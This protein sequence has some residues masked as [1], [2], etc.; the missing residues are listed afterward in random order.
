MWLLAD[1]SAGA[2]WWPL[3]R[4]LLLATVAV[5]CLPAWW[6]LLVGVV[7]VPVFLLAMLV[8]QWESGQGLLLLAAGSWGLL[9]LARLAVQV[10][11]PQR[12]QRVPWWGLA[13]GVLAQVP[14]LGGWPRDLGQAWF[15]FGALL[16]LV[17]LLA[18]RRWL[19]G[20]GRR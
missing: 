17:L 14:L 11:W 10:G 5:L 8:G 18:L 9:A 20:R 4:V 15:Q 19:P 6:M 1:A 2:R 3:A 7:F 12:A 16:A 13:A